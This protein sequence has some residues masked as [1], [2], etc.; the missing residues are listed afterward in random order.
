MEKCVADGVT[1]T[2]ICKNKMIVTLTVVNGKTVD[3]EKL[4]FTLKC[5]NSPDGDCPCTCDAANDSLCKCRDLVAPLR[6]SLSKSPLTASYPISYVQSFNWWVHEEVLQREKC[7]DG[8]YD[9]HP[10]CPWF[11]MPGETKPVADSQGFCCTCKMGQVWRD[12]WGVDRN[13]KRGNLDCGWNPKHIIDKDPKSAHC[14]KFDSQWYS[15]YSLGPAKMFFDITVK[16]VIPTGANASSTSITE[17]LQLNPGKPMAA[18]SSRLVTAKL[19]GDL[20]TYTQLPELSNRLLVLPEPSDK[21]ANRTSHANRSPRTTWMIIDKNKFSFDGRECDKVGTSFSAFRYHENACGRPPGTC[22][23]NQLKDL[24]ERDLKAIKEGRTPMHMVTQFTG[25][26]AVELSRDTGPLAFELPVTSTSQSIVT[27]SV[28]ADTVRLVTNR[29]PGQITN[30]RVCR[31]AESSCGGFESGARGYIRMNVTNLGRLAADFTIS[32]LNCT[33]N[34]RRIEARRVSLG[35]GETMALSPPIELYVEDDTYAPNRTCLTTLYDALGNVADEEMMQFYTNATK[36]DPK[37]VGGLNGTGNGPY[38]LKLPTDCK[39]ACPNFFS[40]FCFLKKRCWALLGQFFAVVAGVAVGITAL[41]LAY[42]L[43]WIS[44]CLDAFCTCRPSP[45]MTYID[46]PQQIAM[47]PIQT[48]RRQQQPALP[49]PPAGRPPPSPEIQM[50][51]AM[52]LAEG[53]R[54][55]P[56]NGNSRQWPFRAQQGAPSGFQP[57]PLPPPGPGEGPWS[58]PVYGNR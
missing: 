13:M 7:K 6:V 48:P 47:A 51:M 58:K 28:A 29:S 4:E 36:Y 20:A 34:V 9:E 31:F 27:L 25:G 54:G 19:V 49:A 42:R 18:T 45:A 1:E 57:R 39:V 21:Q 55:L 38:A 3:T 17:T 16:V 56:N 8:A 2:L 23:Q 33:V 26:D 22:L 43:G 32:I 46:P 11:Y 37:P 40:V 5:V 12:T 50:Q 53:A 14:M 15:A 35:P 24:W 44:A 30:L 41:V 52:Q 10:S